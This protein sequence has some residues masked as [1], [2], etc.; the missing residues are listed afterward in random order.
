MFAGW[1]L[2]RLGLDGLFDGVYLSSDCGCK[3]PD[4]RFFQTLLRQR[5][6]DPGQAVMIGNDGICDVQGA[7]AVGLA[8]VYIRSNLSPA[9]PA[10][11]ADYVLDEMDLNRVG[12]ILT[13]DGGPA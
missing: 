10:P 5:G 9:G 11:G 8:A 13:G 4:P 2:E 7:K 12:A 1:E 3:K 6:I